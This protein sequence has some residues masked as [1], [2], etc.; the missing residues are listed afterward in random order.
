MR[1]T[2]SR[3]FHGRFSAIAVN[4]SFVILL[5]LFIIG[6]PAG[7]PED[8]RISLALILSLFHLYVL[9]FLVLLAWRRWA[10]VPHE[11]DRI[12]VV[13]LFRG[14]HGGLARSSEA[15]LA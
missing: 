10:G 5:I 15:G 7:I 13:R 9:V 6:P 14:V 4:T 2:A 3:R 8:S 1:E 11:F 12:A